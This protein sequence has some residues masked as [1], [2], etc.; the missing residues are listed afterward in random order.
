MSKQMLQDPTT[1]LA[2]NHAPNEDSDIQTPN[3]DPP[4]PHP[5][6]DSR[7]ANPAALR[8]GPSIDY[9]KQRLEKLISDSNRRRTR[10][11]RGLEIAINGVSLNENTIKDMTGVP[12]EETKNPYGLE[13]SASHADLPSNRSRAGKD[14]TCNTTG[15]ISQ[16]NNISSTRKPQI[17]YLERNKKLLET[18]KDQNRT[19]GNIKGASN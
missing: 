11:Q 14:Q 7:N 5:Q 13:E 19:T 18:P 15:Y 9:N 1:V 8:K 10:Y 3:L 17:N 4:M 16:T 2:G 12:I 6:E